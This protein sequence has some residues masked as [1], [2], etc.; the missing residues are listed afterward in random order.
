MRR[1]GYR[2]VDVV[3]DYF[4]PAAFKS[5]AYPD[6]P[7]PKC[8][9]QRSELRRFQDGKIS[10]AVVWD[11]APAERHLIPDRLVSWALTA[12]L[13]SGSTVASPSPSVSGRGPSSGGCSGALDG[14]LLQRQPGSAASSSSSG[15]LLDPSAG[16]ASFRLMEA[17]LGDIAG[18]FL[19]PPVSHDVPT[20]LLTSIAMRPPPFQFLPCH[21][22]PF[23]CRQ[24]W[25]A[26]EGH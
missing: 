15:Q 24:A 18:Y 9:G 26:A 17:A 7:P 5:L 20:L 2:G 13:P 3:V 14:V 22:P 10:E 8:H 21:L 6:P 16:V 23:Y 25:E 4:H 19:L 11:C 12:H 1:C